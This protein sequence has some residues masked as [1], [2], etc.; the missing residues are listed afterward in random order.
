MIDDQKKTVL[1]NIK[2]CSKNAFHHFIVKITT[3]K[4]SFFYIFFLCERYML[5]SA[6]RWDSYFTTYYNFHLFI[7]ICKLFRYQSLK[8]QQNRYFRE[9]PFKS[10]VTKS[11]NKNAP[12]FKYFLEELSFHEKPSFVSSISNFFK[13]TSRSSK[14]MRRHSVPCQT[15]IMNLSAKIITAF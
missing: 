3:S 10:Y 12:K 6:G 5:M 9:V 8:N 1:I 11:N 14:F 2:W 4:K 7:S 13:K 15:S